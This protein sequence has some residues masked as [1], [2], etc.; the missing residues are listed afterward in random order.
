MGR[1]LSDCWTSHRGS[2]AAFWLP[3]D[4]CGTK[5]GVWR[6]LEA[7]VLEVVAF[8]SSF[9]SARPA[10]WPA[11]RSRVYT[12]C[13]SSSPFLSCC[14]F[15]WE[16]VSSTPGWVVCVVPPLGK[17]CGLFFFG[18][19]W[20]VHLGRAECPKDTHVYTRI[21]SVARLS[22]GLCFVVSLDGRGRRMRTY[23]SWIRALTAPPKS[24]DLVFLP[25]FFR[26]CHVIFFVPT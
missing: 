15:G 2:C 21:P 4:E 18:A 1:L 19:S 23:P 20:L 14:V 25:S 8:S 10:P 22:S 6:Y 9:W 5:P 17:H 3:L 13:V 7:Q 26:F 11:P 12:G 16:W 24:H